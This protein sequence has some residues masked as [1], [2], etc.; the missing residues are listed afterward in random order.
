M[1]E[2]PL[3]LNYVCHI[4]KASGPPSIF[5]DGI[6]VFS[7]REN[8]GPPMYPKTSKCEDAAELLQLT[9]N[10]LT[11]CDSWRCETGN[12]LFRLEPSSEASVSPD[13]RQRSESLL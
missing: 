1:E 9:N 5:N 7:D 12:N 11:I 6:Y 8:V 4:P 2:K 3:K 13:P 10:E